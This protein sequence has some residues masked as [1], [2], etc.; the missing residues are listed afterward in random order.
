MTLTDKKNNFQI[1][2]HFVLKGKE[3]KFCVIRMLYGF[4]GTVL[5]G[6]RFKTK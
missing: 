2:E 5:R 4:K 3:C 6:G 1:G